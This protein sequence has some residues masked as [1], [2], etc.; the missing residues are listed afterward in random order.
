VTRWLLA[1]QPN[2]RGHTAAS[3]RPVAV[4]PQEPEKMLAQYL[5]RFKKGDCALVW[6]E[7]N[8]GETGAEQFP[9]FCQ[10]LGSTAAT[11]N[12]LQR[13]A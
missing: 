9:V 1:Q 8:R 3:V 10:F 13:K 5:P 7:E 4:D 11:G 12:L 6:L 2:S